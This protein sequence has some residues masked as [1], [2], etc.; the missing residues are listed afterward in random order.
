MWIAALVLFALAGGL[1]VGATFQKKRLAL[2]AVTETSK[3]AQ[4]AAL[5]QSVA[6]E[7]GAGSF[8]ELVE[9]KGVVRCEQPIQSELAR[10][11]CVHYSMEVIRE[12]EETT[13]ETDGSGKRQSA[14][15]RGSETVAEHE[16]SCPF[17]V[18]DETGRIGVDPVGAK[19]I[20]E[21]VCDRFEPG[22]TPAALAPPA[23]EPLSWLPPAAAVVASAPRRT[24]GYRYREEAIPVGKTIYVLGEASDQGGRMVVRKPAKGGTF[25]VSVKGEEE[26]TSSARRGARWLMVGTAVSAA[27][28][29]V[30][31]LLALLG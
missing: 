14:V 1:L 8:T 28:G 30:T 6:G 22:E 29:V 15:G 12:Y 27:G 10:V 2:M 7:I 11:P 24:L 23:D 31:G 13:W 5:A 18:E 20:A 16:R 9:V 26:L 25:L 3:T 17:Q 21:Q 19:I 4:L